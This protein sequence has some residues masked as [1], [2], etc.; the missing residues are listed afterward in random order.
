MV[1]TIPIWVDFPEEFD[2]AM[3][4]GWTPICSLKNL[5]LTENETI[6]EYVKTCEMYSTRRLRITITDP[7]ANQTDPTV[8]VTERAYN[9]TI[10]KIPTYNY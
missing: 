9:L 10:S 5:N 4:L 2:E 3:Y 8:T 6:F 1:S 7:L